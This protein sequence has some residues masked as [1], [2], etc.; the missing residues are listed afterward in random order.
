MSSLVGNDMD[1][2]YDGSGFKPNKRRKFVNHKGK[3]GAKVDQ[4]PQVVVLS[5]ETFTE[6][7]ALA[8]FEDIGE[9]AQKEWEAEKEKE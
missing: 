5:E 9:A 2:Y 8:F 7:D 6:E 3:A 1:L 4:E